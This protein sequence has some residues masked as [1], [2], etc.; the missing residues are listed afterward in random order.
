MVWRKAPAGA[1]RTTGEKRKAALKSA[2][3]AYVDAGT[4]TGILGYHEG[5]PVA[6]CSIAPRSSY[7]PLGGPPAE[8]S[9]VA[10]SLVCF[11]VRRAFR[12]QGVTDRL[13]EAAMAYAEQ[14]GATVI[15]AYPVDPDSPSYRFMG[16]VCQFERAGFEQVGTAGSRRYVMRRLLS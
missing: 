3:C 2:L 7:R 10:W 9:E 13:L 15:E 6:W 4:A 16:F 5:E 14:E 1:K 8:A 12:R 11:Y